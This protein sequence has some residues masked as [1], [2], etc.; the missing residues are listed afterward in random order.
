[1]DNNNQQQHTQRKP[2]RQR[3][4]DRKAGI[5]EVK[6]ISSR[7]KKILKYLN[8]LFTI[9]QYLGLLMLLLSLATI[10]KNNYIVNNWNLIIIYSVMFIIGRA[11]ITIQSTIGKFR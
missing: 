1:M 11:G 4:A 8:I 2:L 3:V 9:M 10:I 7:S 5:K 6:P